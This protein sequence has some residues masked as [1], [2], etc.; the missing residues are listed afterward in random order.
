MS[1]GEAREIARLVLENK[2]RSHVEAARL[3]ALFVRDLEPAA[4]VACLTD[5]ERKAIF[6]AYC[7]GCGSADRGCQ[8]WDND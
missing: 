5:E 6:D 1:P 7:G 4:L 3:L 8:C 2:T